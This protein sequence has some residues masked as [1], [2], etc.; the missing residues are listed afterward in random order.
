MWNP[1]LSWKEI[2]FSLSAFWVQVH[3]LPPSWFNKEYVELIRGKVG[4]VLEVD[5]IVEPRIL[6]QRFV[7]CRINID[8]TTP[9]CPG[10]FLPRKDRN[11]IWISL[12]YERLPEVCFQCGVLGH[13]E[14]SCDNERTSL[15]NEFGVQFFAFGDWLKTDN[16]KFPLG[17]YEQ[18]PDLQPSGE[19]SSAAKLRFNFV[20]AELV[21]RNGE[22]VVQRDEPSLVAI[23]KCIG[24]SPE[25]GRTTPVEVSSFA[26]LLEHALKDDGRVSSSWSSHKTEVDSIRCVTPHSKIL[27]SSTDNSISNTCTVR[28]KPS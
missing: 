26:L 9:L 12:K 21:S 15:A 23:N 11:D 3:G 13:T 17:I 7:R 14:V 1:E 20:D 10:M 4:R 2:G 24:L 5:L 19:R 27:N 28:P 16:D 8:I 18:P 6:W 22:V 25:G